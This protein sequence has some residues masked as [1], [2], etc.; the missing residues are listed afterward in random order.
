MASQKEIVNY[1]FKRKA[2]SDLLFECR[3]GKVRKQ[4]KLRGHGNLMDHITRDQKN[5]LEEVRNNAGLSLQ[6]LS[7][8]ISDK[9]MK[10]YQWLDWVSAGL[11][12]SLCEKNLTRKYTKLPEISVKTLVSYM[13]EMVS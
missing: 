4:D 12:F 10:I 1:Y 3:C 7:P 2:D 11:P 5:Y 9:A 13:N 6:L 8:N